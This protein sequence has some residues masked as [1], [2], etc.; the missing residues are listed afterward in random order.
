[1]IRIDWEHSPQPSFISILQF[2]LHLVALMMGSILHHDS[3]NWKWKCLLNPKSHRESNE[4]ES[5]AK[6]HIADAT[7]LMLWSLN[8]CQWNTSSAEMHV[9]AKLHLAP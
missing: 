5:E 7:S 3:T 2:Q 8:D 4:A 1:M 6:G 9:N